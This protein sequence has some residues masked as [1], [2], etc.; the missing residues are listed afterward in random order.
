MTE[1]G[2]KILIVDDND[3]NRDTLERRLRQQGFSSEMA[4]NGREALEK[5]NQKPY[6]LVLLDIMMPEADGFEVL[7][8]IRASDHLK[9]VPVIMISAMEEIE[10]VMRCIEIGAEDY[11][12]KPFDPVLLQAAI[13]RCLKLTQASPRTP[14]Q[15][16]ARTAIKSKIENTVATTNP[17]PEALPIEEV[18]SRI[19]NS[20][21]ISRKG[22]RHLTSSIHNSLFNRRLLSQAEF[23]GLQQLFRQIADNQIKIID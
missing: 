15:P 16:V 10:S 20:G 3:M 8:T 11:L 19:I 1:A 6:D 7:T 18:V 17:V 21:R 4:F 22:Y 13:A 5:L 23:E 14:V 2:Y 12:T 9:H